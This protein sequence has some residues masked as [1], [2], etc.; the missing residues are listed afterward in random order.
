MNEHQG[1]TAHSE[2][3]TEGR[4]PVHSLTTAR[5]MLPLVQRIVDDVLLSRRGLSRLQPEEERLHRVRR[6]LTWPERERRYAL[7]D[8]L[9]KLEKTLQAA[10]AEMEGLGVALL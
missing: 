8:E 4:T 9:A 1:N 7:Q 6:E 2:E 3:E 10:L 5:R